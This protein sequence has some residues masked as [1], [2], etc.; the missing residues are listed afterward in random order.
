MLLSVLPL[1]LGLPV[2]A[3]LLL[4][5]VI[6]VVDLPEVFVHRFL[7]CP[8]RLLV[9]TQ[10]VLEARVAGSGLAYPS[11][12][13]RCGLLGV[14]EVRL[15]RRPWSTSRPSSCRLSSRSSRSPLFLPEELLSESVFFWSDAK[16]H[17]RVH[18]PC[19]VSEVR[20]CRR[21]WSTSRPSSCRL[22]SRSAILTF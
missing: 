14:S 5:W 4:R 12:M 1:S 2:L 13:L 20:L 21:P 10:P 19:R 8:A 9:M 17:Y 7:L 15:C 16:G 11:P 22:S 3:H 18:I 6:D